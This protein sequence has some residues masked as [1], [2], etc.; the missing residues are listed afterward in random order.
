MTLASCAMQMTGSNPPASSDVA[1]NA[2][3]PLCLSMVTGWPLACSLWMLCSATSEAVAKRC[4]ASAN[5]VVRPTTAGVLLH[6][7]FPVL[8]CRLSVSQSEKKVTEEL[9]FSIHSC[10]S[11]D[12]IQN[13][14][15]VEEVVVCT[16]EIG[17]LSS[18]HCG[19]KWKVH[20]WRK[21]TPVTNE[22][23]RASSKYLLAL[24]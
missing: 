10:L 24:Q 15:I 13:D 16:S 9:Q 22:K 1:L 14:G 17:Q 18:G 4:R 6:Q 3:G 2:P 23:D 21:L 20:D 5:G 12:L 19:V 11:H 7:V 8:H